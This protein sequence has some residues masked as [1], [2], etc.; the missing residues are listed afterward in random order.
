MGWLL[1]PSMTKKNFFGTPL[2]LSSA[3]KHGRHTL[4]SCPKL[5][6]AQISKKVV[7]HIFD[8]F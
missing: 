5:S 4:N 2:K 1:T 6:P 8:H 3:Q 7:A